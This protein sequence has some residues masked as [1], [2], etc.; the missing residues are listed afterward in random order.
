MT[1]IRKKPWKAASKVIIY[2]KRLKYY[3]QNLCIFTGKNIVI[4]FKMKK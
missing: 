4:N 1:I 3:L 2:N